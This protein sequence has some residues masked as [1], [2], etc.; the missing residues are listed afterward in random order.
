MEWHLLTTKGPNP[1]P[2]AGHS[3]TLVQNNKMVV[4]G[5]GVVDGYSNEL[6]FLDLSFS[7]IKLFFH[8]I[9]DTLTWEKPTIIGTAP[10]P[11][12]G[13]TAIPILNKTAVLVF[14]GGFRQKVFGD[15]HMFD[16]GL[17]LYFNK[18]IY[19][20]HPAIYFFLA[21]YF[22]GSLFFWLFI[23]SGFLF[24]VNLRFKQ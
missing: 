18:T 19:F 2:R 9:L 10:C 24:Y 3:A 5:G 6:F 20:I 8:V 13:H 4:F 17:A 22:F 23:F 12:A 21:F 14:G 7:F 15:L 1:S 11:R 16:I